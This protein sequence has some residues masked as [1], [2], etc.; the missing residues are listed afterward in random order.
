MLKQ[1]DLILARLKSKAHGSWKVDAAAE[2]VF[3]TKLRS[4]S[5]VEF[6]RDTFLGKNAKSSIDI[7]EELASELESQAQAAAAQGKVKYGADVLTAT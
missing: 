1:V 3:S 6:L 5:Q 4:A 2:P 7:D